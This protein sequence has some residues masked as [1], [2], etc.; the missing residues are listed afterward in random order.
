[1]DSLL[2]VETEL[3]ARA[4]ACL[5]SAEHAEALASSLAEEA[6]EEGRTVLESREMLERALRKITQAQQS[7]RARDTYLEAASMISRVRGPKG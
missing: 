1:M 2:S 6:S 3:R 5:K 7:R 4:A